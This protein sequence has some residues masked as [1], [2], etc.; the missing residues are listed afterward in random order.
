[1]IPDPNHVFLPNRHERHTV[2][3]TGTHDND[4]VLGWWRSASAEEHECET[5]ADLL[6]LQYR[7]VAREKALP[8]PVRALERGRQEVAIG[9]V[10]DEEDAAPAAEIG[11]GADDPVR[12]NAVT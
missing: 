6:R 11:E 4:T 9:L 7:T 3:Y 2:V 10:D 1:M 5:V 12:S 8:E